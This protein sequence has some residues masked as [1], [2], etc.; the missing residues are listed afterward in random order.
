MKNQDKTRM[1]V[2]GQKGIVVFLGILLVLNFS[3]AAPG[4]RGMGKGV[5]VAQQILKPSL[6]HISGKLHEIKTHPCENTTGRANLGTHLILKD[7]QGRELNIHL[8]PTTELSESVKQLKIGKKIELIGFRTD[9]MPLNQYV[10][11]TLILGSHIIQLRDSDLRPYWA[12]NRLSQGTLLPY[13][14]ATVDQRKVM[15][16][17][18]YYYHP[19]FWRRR[20]FKNEQR[21]RWRRSCGRRAFCRRCEW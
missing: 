7:K 16:R 18:F 9:K 12:G 14:K 2:V 17:N 20:C 19:K 4:Q 6:V 15:R 21:P 10:A 3:S 5:G 1:N 8:G 11:Q 13:V